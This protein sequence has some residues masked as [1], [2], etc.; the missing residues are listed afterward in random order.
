[1]SFNQQPEQDSTTPERIAEVL[2]VRGSVDSIMQCDNPTMGMSVT[3][4]DQNSVDPIMEED[5]YTGPL[6][7]H[8]IMRHS[9]GS[10][11]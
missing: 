4:E 3:Q 1:M 11:D 8:P 5:M 2:E 9:K 7:N 6:P 10:L